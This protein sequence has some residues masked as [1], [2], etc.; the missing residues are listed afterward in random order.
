MDP[1]HHGH[2]CSDKCYLIL[3]T[4]KKLGCIQYI[5]YLWQVHQSEGGGTHLKP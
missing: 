5:L 3:Y 4:Y 1:K 2:L